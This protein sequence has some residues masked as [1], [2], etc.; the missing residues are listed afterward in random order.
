MSY[1]Y[2][3]KPESASYKPQTHAKEFVFG[4][5][6]GLTDYLIKTVPK[7]VTMATHGH[8]QSAHTLP[9]RSTSQSHLQE[10]RRSKKISRAK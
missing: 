7:F 9:D 5:E 10:N 6:N 4:R 8:S 1:A 3:R 2:A